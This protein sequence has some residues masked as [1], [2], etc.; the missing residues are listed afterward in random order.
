MPL[1]E[2]AGQILTEPKNA[3]VKQ[4]QQLFEF[5]NAKLDFTEDALQ[6]YIARAG[7]R[8]AKTGARAL[9]ASSSRRSCSSSCS[10]LPD[11]AILFTD[12][13]HPN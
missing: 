3:L 10:T 12:C 7:H 4:Y 9:R 13:P 5:E 2:A 8:R 1:D 11:V 6:G